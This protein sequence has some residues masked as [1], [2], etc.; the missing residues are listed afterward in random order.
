MT[1]RTA[2]RAGATAL[3]LGGWAVLLRGLYLLP[4]TTVPEYDLEAGGRFAMSIDVYLP[5]LA[6][7]LLLLVVGPFVVLRRHGS[8]G[9][10]A[11]SATAAVFLGWVSQQDAL[12]SYVPD[13]DG[14]ILMAFGL[15]AAAFFLYLLEIVARPATREE[16]SAE[17]AEDGLR[18]PV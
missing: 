11:A 5:A 1:G 17:V 2:T 8:I 4:R 3:L 13:L 9:G 15:V 7:S 14:A 6:L 16:P 18:D 12:Q 10:V